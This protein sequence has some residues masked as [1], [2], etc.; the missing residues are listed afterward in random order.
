MS[1]FQT[2]VVRTHLQHQDH[3]KVKEALAIYR[4]VFVPKIENIRATK[5]EQY[6]YGFLDDLFVKVLGFT[7]N[8]TPDYNLIAEQKNT[9]DSRKAD[10]A[11]LREGEVIGVI[12]LKSTQT[13]IMDKIVDQA[14]GYKHSHPACR[15][16]ITSNFETLRLYIDTSDA[17]EEFDLF[18]MDEERFALLYALL[19]YESIMGDVPLTLKH[20]SKLQEENISN[21]LYRKYAGLRTQMFDNLLQRNPQIDRAVLLTKTQTILDRMVF[22]FFAEDRGILPPNTIASIIEHY[23]SDIE[24]RPLW[25]F[26]TIYFR[27]IH[28][29]NARL[30]I[31]AY[32]GGLFAPDEVLDALVID[33]AV[34]EACPLALSAYDF[35]S[36]VDVNILGHIFENSLNDIEELKAR[37][38]DEDFDATRSRRKKDGVFYTPE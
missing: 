33:D 25:H 38:N 35:N 21:E 16:V 2:S 19:S 8:P 4:S 11:I 12:E 6:Q 29:G 22:I 10:G 1:L 30:G 34:I 17:Y 7:L 20:Q 13:R 18:D 32:N 27:A 24:S 3:H 37:I 36:E 26:Y 23:R 9:A 31:P 14:F 28:E 5:E 15:Y